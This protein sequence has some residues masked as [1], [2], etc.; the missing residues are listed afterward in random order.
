MRKLFLFLFLLFVTNRLTAQT[1]NEDVDEHSEQEAVPALKNRPG[2]PPKLFINCVRTD[3]YSNYLRTKLAFFDF[4][5]DRLVSDIEVLMTDQRTGAGGNEYT[6]AFYGHNRFE[7]LNDTLRFATQQSDTD[8]QIR[9]QLVRTMKQG[10]VRYLLDSDFME[11]VD[12]KLPAR[13]TDAQQ[14][15]QPKDPWNYWVFRVGG[16]GS[17]RGES[18]KQYL[19]FST[20]LRASRITEPRQVYLPQLL[21]RQPQQLHRRWRGHPRPHR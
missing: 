3:C 7:G 6:L 14:A 15:D 10:L 21:Q 9:T 8:D 11:Q 18:N 4:V 12:I 19:S 16:R 1:A 13:Q 17:A 2:G 5:R 20:Y